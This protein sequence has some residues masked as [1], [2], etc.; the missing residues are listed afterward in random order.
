MLQVQDLRLFQQIVR[1]GNI[2]AAAR[3]F[4]FTPAAASAALK[5]LE[6][7]LGAALLL[8]STRSLKLT[9]AGE[10][11][12]QHCQNALEALEQGEQALKNLAVDIGGELRLAAPSDLGRNWLLPKLDT[13]LARFPQLKLR[14]ELGDRVAG[15]QREPVDVAL[16]YGALTDPAL[17]AFFIAEVPRIVCAAP[18]YLARVGTPTQPLQ[19]QQHNCLLYMIEERTFDRW[20]FSG[21][22]GLLQVNVQGNRSSNDAE[23]VRRWAVAGHGIALKSA[24]D[25]AADLR[26]GHVVPLLPDYPAPKLQLHLVCAS[27]HQVTPAVL[28]LRDE[29]R[30]WVAAELATLRL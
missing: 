28:V 26:A 4:D 3:Q 15:L 16:R 1:S 6:Q 17:V 9:P 27:R 24:L 11:F 20:R 23:L 30:Q 13:L 18:D 8:R 12:L 7:H 5:R 10:V 21:P 2:S 22:Q 14:L 29:L 25:M 19:L